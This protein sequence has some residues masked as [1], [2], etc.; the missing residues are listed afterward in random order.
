MPRWAWTLLAGGLIA[1]AAAAILY[2]MALRDNPARAATGEARQTSSGDATIEYRAH[3]PTTGTAVLLFPSFARSAAD[4][5]EL[6]LD[7]SQAGFRTL[8]VQPRGVEGSTLPSGDFTYHTYAG[9]MAAVL[10]AEGVTQPAFVLGH[11]FGNRI[12]RTFAADYPGRTRGVVLFAAG[13]VEPT[14]PEMGDAIGKAMIRDYPEETRREAIA[15]AFFADGNAVGEDWMRGWYPEAGL[16]EQTATILTPYKEWGDAG[17]APILVL[18]PSEDDVAVNGGR[19]LKEAH[20][21]RVELV[22]VERA[23]HAILPER[24]EQI[25]AETLRFLSE[26]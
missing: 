9:D 11:A 21:D 3:G 22:I 6:V 25:S 26:H 15:F 10:D 14:P 18:Q 7:L 17:T 1:V 12:A 8:A 5:N 16:A 19:L 24:P 23:G 20:P 2:P 13:G 4:F